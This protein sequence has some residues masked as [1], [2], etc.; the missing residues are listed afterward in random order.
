MAKLLADPS[1]RRLVGTQFLT[2]FNDNVFKQTV[3]LLAVFAQQQNQ[4]SA[5]ADL[6]LQALAAFFFALPFL[7]FAVFAG[8]LA[9]RFSKRQVVVATKIAEAGIMLAAAL[10]FWTGSLPLGILVLFFMGTQSAFLGPAK[11]GLVPELV[12]EKDLARANGHMQGSVLVGIILGMGAAGFLVDRLGQAM[13]LEGVVLAAIAL[14]GWKVAR[15]IRPVPAADPL[16]RPGLNPFRRLMEG[17]RTAAKTPPLLRV[18]VANSMFWLAGALVLPCWN[19]MAGELEVSA[20]IWSGALGALALS[21]ALGALAAG[22]ASRRRLRV[23]LAPLGGFALATALLLVSIGPRN[24]WFPFFTL[25][26]GNFFSSFY[27]IPLQT[28][29]QKLPDDEHLGLVLGTNQSL[30]WIFILGASA[31]KMLATALGFDPFETFSWIAAI[32]ALGSFWI[33][34]GKLDMALEAADQTP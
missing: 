26:C 27:L 11:Y 5:L 19:E 15:G 8:D 17:F 25:L 7:M 3:L 34:P 22:T 14:Y 33:R 28:L 18:L 20:T 21:Q 10:A 4:G 31:L 12:E 13:W 16:R 1:F 30:N 2:V 29:I 32:L 23:R 6:D 9:D 24:P